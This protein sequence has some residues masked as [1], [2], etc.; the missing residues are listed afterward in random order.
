MR[1]LAGSTN[2]AVQQIKNLAENMNNELVPLSAS[3][4]NLAEE[5]GVT[6]RKSQA[7]FEKMDSAVGDDS[8][9]AYQL[10]KTLKELEGAA[11]SIRLLA[12]E[13]RQHPEAVVWGKKKAKGE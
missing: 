7:A 5:T 13:L 8:A 4:K 10:P 6:L 1:P 2:E 9:L 11:R 3:I 12:N